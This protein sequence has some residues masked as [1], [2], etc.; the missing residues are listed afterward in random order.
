[1]SFLNFWSKPDPKVEQRETDKALRKVNRDLERDRLKLEREE[2]KLEQ[3]I[4]KLAKAGDQEG[5]RILAKQ[6]V[7]MRKQK[8]RSYAASS[9]VTGV[10]FQNKAMGANMK[11]AESMGVAGKTMADMNSLMKPEQLAATVNAFTKENMK[12]EMTD[13]MI[14]D[15]L[16]DM[17]TESGDEE[18]SDNIV[19]QVLD[20]IGIEM[21]GKMS[22]APLPETGKIGQKSKGLSD[23]DIEAQLA[24]LKG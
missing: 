2:K 4:K 17:L 11:L 6:L 9:K 23:E 5:C 22:G 18:E 21:S 24:K 12:M 14:N 20:E 8:T 1:M 15:T 19:T 10:Q 13:E 7:Q 16:D 3:E